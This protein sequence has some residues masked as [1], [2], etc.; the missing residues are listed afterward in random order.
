MGETYGS[1]LLPAR[2]LGSGSR[3]RDGGLKKETSHK[4]F[5]LSFTRKGGRG[6]GKG[7]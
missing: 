2:S 6:G 7:D 4:R 5:L 3:E 1:I